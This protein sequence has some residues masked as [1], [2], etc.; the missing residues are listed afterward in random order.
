MGWM[1][2]LLHVIL[3]MIGHDFAHEDSEWYDM[4]NNT[5]RSSQELLL[6]LFL[7]CFSYDYEM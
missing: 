4:Y 7:N 6:V 2:H 3:H 1:P 5:T